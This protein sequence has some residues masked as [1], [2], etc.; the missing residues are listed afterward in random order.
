MQ[1]STEDQIAA[2]NR[3]AEAKRH[4]DKTLCFEDGL[5]AVRAWKEFANVF[6]PGDR[7]FPLDSPPRKVAIFPMHKTRMP[8][9]LSRRG[10][11]E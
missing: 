3:F 1:V 6:L 11:R 8:D 7:Q 2:W 5:A 9:D 10:H 4:A